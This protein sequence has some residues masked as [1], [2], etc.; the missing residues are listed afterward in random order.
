MERLEEQR[1]VVFGGSSGIGLATARAFARQGASVVIAARRAANVREATDQ[2]VAGGGVATGVVA[3]V[4]VREQV[5]AAVATAIEHYGGLT[6]LVNAA[7]TNIK[8]RRMAELS[9]ADWNRLLAINLTGAFHTTQAALPHMRA[10]GGGLIIQ[11]SSVSGRWG[12][13]SGAA[14]QASKHGIVGLCYATMVEERLNGIRVTALLPGLCDTPLLARR[15]QPP[16]REILDQAMQPEDV[17]AACLLLATLPARTYV[18]E[19]L[20]LPGALQYVGNTVI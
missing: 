4:A 18:P 16:A 20:L 11:I 15:P 6:V 1:V 9:E 14:Y 7:G 3:D 19:M 17:A 12:D 5:D 8:T 10:H 13:L 2:I